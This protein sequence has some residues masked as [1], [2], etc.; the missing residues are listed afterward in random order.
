MSVTFFV[1]SFFAG[2]LATTRGP[3]LAIGG[4]MTLTGLGLTGLAAVGAHTSLTL[5]MA[6]LL[7]VGVGLG[8]ITGPIANAA[9][10]NVPAARAGM[11]SGLVNV[12]RLIGATR[13]VGVL[14]L[15]FGG[16]IT[17]SADGG[18]FVAGMRAACLMGA[19]AQ[20]LGA[21]IAFVGFRGP[22]HSGAASAG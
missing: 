5:V 22:S 17:M 10:A 13:G 21:A 12:G 9:V 3:R 16:S 6:P 7:S 8:L 4:G 11:A 1:V 15:V 14:G 2:R 19:V 18:G 20:F